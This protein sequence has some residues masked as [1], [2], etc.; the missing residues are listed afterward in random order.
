VRP[1]NDNS[2]LSQAILICFQVWYWKE[3]LLAGRTTA[4]KGIVLVLIL[5]KNPG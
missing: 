1:A 5:V 3:M 2:P 4:A